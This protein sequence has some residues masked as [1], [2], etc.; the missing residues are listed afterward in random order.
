MLSTFVSSTYQNWIQDQGTHSRKLVRLCWQLFHW[1]YIVKII[2]SFILR[3]LSLTWPFS[4]PENYTSA[5]L[6]IRLGIIPCLTQWNLCESNML[7]FQTEFLRVLARFSQ[8][9]C[10][11]FLLK[12][13]SQI[14]VANAALISEY[15]GSRTSVSL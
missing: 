7:H 8:Y 5:S 15:T 14:G 10:S 4:K 2:Y 13:L 3:G 6:T 1:L 9:F 12:T 11:L